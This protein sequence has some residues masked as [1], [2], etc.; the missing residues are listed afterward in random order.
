MTARFAPTFATARGIC[1]ESTGKRRRRGARATKG[2]RSSPTPSSHSA[3]A[4]ELRQGWQDPLL[5]LARTFIVGLDDV[6]RGADALS[7]AEQNGYVLTDRE[8]LLLADGYR[9]RGNSLVRSAKQLKGLPQEHE[10][11]SRAAEVSLGALPL[12]QRTE[13][14][15]SS[16]Q[17]RATQR[18]LVEVEQTLGEGFTALPESE[19]P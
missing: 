11:L 9:S 10:Y 2:R 13:H 1:T 8:S 5:G 3:K 18:A 12:R 15:S 17:R 19:Q 6:E 7:K 14:R 4:A 16:R